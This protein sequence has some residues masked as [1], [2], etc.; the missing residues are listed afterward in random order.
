M[1]YDFDC[2]IE[3]CGTNCE[4]Y[5]SLS[6]IF[7]TDDLLPL[8]VADMDF[9]TPK[10]IIDALSE[11]LNHKVL[12]YSYR[13]DS[14]FSAIQ[15]WLK[16]RWDWDI[17]TSWVEFTPGTVCAV[18]L[19]IRAFTSVGDGVVIQ[20]PVYGPFSWVINGNNRHVECNSLK[21]ES[22]GRAVIDFEDLEEKLSRSK[23]FILC[24][25]HNPTGRV[26]TRDELV[27]IAELCRKYNIIVIADE[28][29]CDLIQKP[30]RHIH[31][32][33]LDEDAAQRSI[34][35]SSAAKSFNIAGLSTTAVI[36]PN[37]K[38]REA[39]NQES[40]AIHI[41]QG[42]IFGTIAMEVAYTH[43]DEWVDNLND[44]IGGNINF[45]MD[46]LAKKLPEV[47]CYAPEAM[48]LM[49]LD[50]RSWGLDHDQLCK[51]MVDKAHLGMS[52]GRFFG[53]EGEQFMRINVAAP[54][55]II[56]Q[57]M[58]QLYEAAQLLK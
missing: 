16:R 54:R 26:Y 27:R 21:Y 42:N 7:G 39:F 48:Y 14:F 37:Q 13:P 10:F 28:I 17:D 18:A 55:V 35:V 51:F 36:I 49:W 45:V 22:N 53:V 19:A 43:G 15:G 41:G 20:T 33:S 47:K 34:T 44:Y 56:E 58:N 1:I 32:A 31:F 5:D 52:Q 50:F 46:F 4:K 11:R 3:R 25:P 6:R 57:A 38:L 9:E 23:M 8:W 24:N 40:E 2:V 12:G 30:Y 29:H